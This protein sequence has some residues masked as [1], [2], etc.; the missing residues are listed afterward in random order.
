MIKPKIKKI[1][2]K[3][4]ALYVLIAGIALMYL[5]LIFNDSVWGD[6][7][8]TMLMMRKGFVEI[9]NY[10]IEA[11][12]APPLFY[13]IAK[14]FTL[15]FGCNVPAV[16]LA[17][18]APVI[19]TMILAA[20]KSKKLFATHAVEISVIFAM[21]LG[22][23]PRAYVL[24]LELRMYTWAMFFVTASAIFAYEYFLDQKNKKAL[25]YFVLCSLGGAYVHHFATFASCFI[26][27]FLYIA[28]I[29]KSRKN[30]R[31]CVLFSIATIAGYLPWLPV[32]IKQFTSVRESFWLNDSNTEDIPDF[33]RWLF[34]GEFTNLFLFLFALVAVGLLTYLL[35]H[36]KDSEAWFAVASIAV[37]CLVV[38]GGIAIS[39]LLRPIFISRYMYPGFGLLCLGIAVGVSKCD[40]RT[41]I[42]NA[43]IALLVVNLPF[44]YV[45]QVRKEYKNG[46]EEF[47]QFAAASFEEEELIYTDVKHFKW[48]VLPYYLPEHPVKKLKLKESTRGLVITGTDFATVQA[49]VPDAEVQYLFQGNVDNHYYFNI[50]RILDK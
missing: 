35:S 37:F 12:I 46:T 11:D 15:V 48:A 31:T 30:I 24:T 4:L 14:I 22:L 26:Y 8:Y 28:L 47:K 49:A 13:Y 33:I 50:Y 36:L 21:L 41:L 42:R 5:S 19:L 17:C 38:V 2:G 27:L 20:C 18:A 29:G 23:C 10:I 43:V 16:K 45:E 9:T 1:P 7:A 34:E 25:V 3:E 39:K 32:F 44:C 6:E 40:Q